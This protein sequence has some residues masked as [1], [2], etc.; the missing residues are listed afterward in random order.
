MEILNNQFIFNI[1]DKRILKVLV[2]PKIKLTNP[3]TPEVIGVIIGII[4]TACG[5]TAFI[6]RLEFKVKNISDRLDKHPFLKAFD[7]AQENQT[8]D[9][10]ENLLKGWRNGG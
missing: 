9:A 1:L 2:F 4:V 7:K 5:A 8:I 6:V 3:F 10:V